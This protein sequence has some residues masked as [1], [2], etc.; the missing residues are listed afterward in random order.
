MITATDYRYFS[1]STT[2]VHNV[3]YPPAIT[4]CPICMCHICLLIHK[5]QDK[6]RNIHGTLEVLAHPFLQLLSDLLL[7]PLINI[8]YKH[9]R[10]K[11]A[12]TGVNA[13]LPDCLFSIVQETHVGCLAHTHI[14]QWGQNF[15]FDITVQACN[16]I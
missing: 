8:S 3:N 12:V 11:G 14:K 7:L 5:L 10:V 4:Y 6:K 2:E 16:I 13:Q 1:F 15:I 9:T